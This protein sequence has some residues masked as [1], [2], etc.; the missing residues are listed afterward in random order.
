MKTFKPCHFRLAWRLYKM[1][2]YIALCNTT[3]TPKEGKEGTLIVHWDKE[4]DIS[5]LDLI[6]RF[7]AMYCQNGEYGEY[8]PYFY[9]VKNDEE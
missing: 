1:G 9:R 6:K 4:T 2:E 5:F 8:M 7:T 3:S